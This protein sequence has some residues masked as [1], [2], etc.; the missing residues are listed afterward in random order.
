[1]ANKITYT[2]A[3]AS[4]LTFIPSEEVEI[5]DK[6]QALLAQLEK[7]ATAPKKPTAKQKESASLRVKL[8][9]EMAPGR[10]YTVSELAAELP[11]LEGLSSQ[12]VSALVRPLV[13]DNSLERVDIKRKAYFSLAG[14]YQE[15]EVEEG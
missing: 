4:A 8:L 5:R 1:M 15:K 11:C 3:L 6:L 7:K 13:E 12:K 9:E 14:T 2:S 10:R